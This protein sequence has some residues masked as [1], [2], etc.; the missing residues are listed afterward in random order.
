MIPSSSSKQRNAFQPTTNDRRAG[1]AAISRRLSHF[2]Q[3]ATFT[4]AAGLNF[5]VARARARARVCVC[6]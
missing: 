5:V 6:V 3:I 2:Q 4:G 1:A